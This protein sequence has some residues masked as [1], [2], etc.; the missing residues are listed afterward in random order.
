MDQKQEK[1]IIKRV[2]AGDRDAYAC[3]V[4]KYKGPVFNLAYRMTGSFQEAED[5]AQ[6]T[7]LKA[8]AAITRF[9]AKK[10]FFPWLY[11]I[12]LNL[13]RNH[14]KRKRKVSSEILQDNITG[15]D[16]GNPEN[17]VVRHQ[18]S[19]KLSRC[20]EKLPADLREAV[21]LRYYQELSF[22][23]VAETLE[24]SLS[25]AKMRVYRGL[26]KLRSFMKDK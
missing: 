5:L 20:L 3:L 13:I 14:L 4:D 23:D 9:D 8:Y 18:E 11:T 17:T 22:G 12:S 15:D 21:I 2:Q 16:T 7:F 1:T 10:R 6:E 25:A 24:I 26:E 19:E